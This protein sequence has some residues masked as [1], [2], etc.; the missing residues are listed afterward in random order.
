M[1]RDNLNN[2]KGHASVITKTLLALLL[3]GSLTTVASD[4]RTPMTRLNKIAAINAHESLMLLNFSARIDK[5]FEEFFDMQNNATYI[6]IRKDFLSTI[7]DLSDYLNCAR[8]DKKSNKE[9]SQM[10]KE[11]EDF[12]E[13][14]DKKAQPILKKG[15][16]PTYTDIMPLALPLK[17]FVHL[18]PDAYFSYV[19][20]LLNSI[21]HRLS[22]K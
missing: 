20:Q 13:T 6:S 14:I 3:V 22:C 1:K 15:S 12:L 2:S 11:L 4:A 5:L 8:I 9:I 21:L 7:E 10:I 17:K 16:R 19:P 18:I